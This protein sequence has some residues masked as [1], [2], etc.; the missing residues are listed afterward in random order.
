MN[1]LD[2]KDEPKLDK[3]GA[4]LPFFEWVI[5]KYFIFP[6]V[7]KTTSN[8]DAKRLFQIESG[9]ILKIVENSDQDKLAKQVLIPRLRGL[10]DSSRYWSVAMAVEHL[11]IVGVGITDTILDLAKGVTSRKPVRIQD[12][13]PDPGASA[14]KVKQEFELM[15]ERFLS[16][17]TECLDANPNARFLHPWFGPMNARQWYILA[18][19]HQ[20]VHRLQMEKILESFE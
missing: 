15:T 19:R 4:G 11:V 14:V 5:A 10:E 20:N 2:I 16:I 13:K 12:V 3:P 1:N 18:G 17:P 6:R 9:K 7:Y 8:E